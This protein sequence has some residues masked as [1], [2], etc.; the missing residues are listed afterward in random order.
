MAAAARS[1][2]RQP[3]TYGPSTLADGAGD[4]VI[5]EADSRLRGPAARTH[6]NCWLAISMIWPMPMTAETSSSPGEAGHSAK[7]AMANVKMAAPVQ[8]VTASLPRSIR[9]PTR[10]AMRIGQI[11]KVAAIRPSQTIDRLQLDRAVGNGDAG[12][13][14]HHLHQQRA[15][16]QRD[17]QPV[18]GVAV[19]EA[20]GKPVE[21]QGQLRALDAGP[22]Q[23]FGIASMAIVASA[24]DRFA[25]WPDL[26]TSGIDAD[27]RRSVS[28]ANIHPS[29][30]TL[31][32]QAHWR[33]HVDASIPDTSMP[34]LP[35]TRR[36]GKLTATI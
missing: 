32:A 21:H 25:A 26:V 33:S 13:R 18:I 20:G 36:C 22:H 23:Q 9:R 7:P 19:S 11:A 1:R 14:R 31:F 5:A 27:G 30:G 4:H 24:L 3:T 8:V 12:Q 15:G 17:Q 16:E 28:A 29:S 35:P 34:T 6:S 10:T 2:R